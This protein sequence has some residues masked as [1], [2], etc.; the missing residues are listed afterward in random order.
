MYRHEEKD[1]ILQIAIKAMQGAISRGP[2]DDSEELV[3]EAFDIA[4]CMV[5]F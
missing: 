2:I 3:G 5:K 4:E 1:L